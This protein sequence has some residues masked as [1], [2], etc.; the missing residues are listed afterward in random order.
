MSQF[1]FTCPLTGCN[2]LV[3]RAQSENPDEAAKELTTTA[4]QHLK[5][6]HPDMHKTHDEVAQDIRA[7]M[8]ANG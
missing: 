1:S 3:M 5:E 2:N 4:E 8:V 6:M 7:H